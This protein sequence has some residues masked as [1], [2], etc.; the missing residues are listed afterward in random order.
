[1]KRVLRCVLLRAQQ[2]ACVEPWP[3]FFPVGHVHQPL[4]LRHPG[5]VHR[6][7]TAQHSTGWQQQHLPP[8]Q[9]LPAAVNRLS[10]LAYFDTS[11]S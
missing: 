11:D 10:S 3:P 4:Q 2:Q 6:D 5:W 9:R 8:E 1:M 7:S